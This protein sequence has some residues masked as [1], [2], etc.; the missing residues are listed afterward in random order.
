M[1]TILKKPELYNLLYQ[2]GS[3][4]KVNSIWKK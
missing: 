2:D 1:Q 3:T 4:I